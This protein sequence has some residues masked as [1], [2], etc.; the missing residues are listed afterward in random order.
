MNDTSPPQSDESVLVERILSGDDEAW[1]AFCETYS[2]IIQRSI[3]R[4]VKDEESAR[5]LY[6]SLLE[7]LKKGT[8]G[9]Y[10]GASTLAAW[11][12]AVARNHCRDYFRSASGVRHVM[13]MLKGMRPEERRFFE[14]YYI[15]GMSM[16]EAYESMRSETGGA[17]SRVDVIECDEA[18]RRRIAKKQLA[19]LTGRLLRPDAGRRAERSIETL[20][21]GKELQDAAARSPEENAD[22]GPFEDALRKL[23]AALLALS[24]RDRLML[25]LRFERGLSLRKTGEIL[26]LGD[27][28]RVHERLAR[29]LAR[30]RETLVESGLSAELAGELIDDLERSGSSGRIPYPAIFPEEG[31]DAR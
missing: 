28:R 16:N 29:L 2:P 14:L 9:S 18:I 24:A 20:P 22:A 12:F 5:D 30:L 15:Q 11:L 25:E 26:D 7:K 13:G 10:R 21:E 17:V 19:K 27:A 6:V 4:Y 3:R 23:R 31:N 1:K 8:L